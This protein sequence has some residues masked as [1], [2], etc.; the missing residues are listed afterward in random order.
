MPT[1]EHPGTRRETLRERAIRLG[2]SP[3]PIRRRYLIAAT[4]TEG[5]RR[6]VIYEP[7]RGSYACPQCLEKLH[8]YGNVQRCPCGSATI[9][10]QDPPTNQLGE[11]PND[12]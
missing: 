5:L 4:W 3:K 11:A 6:G 8:P 2:R 12:A 10:T 1:I 9:D 7:T